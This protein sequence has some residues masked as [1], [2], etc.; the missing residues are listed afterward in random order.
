MKR[1]PYNVL[2]KYG[3]FHI[4]YFA[5]IQIIY[6]NREKSKR[7]AKILM[8]ELRKYCMNVLVITERCNLQIF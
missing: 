3:W 4:K 8:D 2:E 7:I 6:E 5:Q 1:R